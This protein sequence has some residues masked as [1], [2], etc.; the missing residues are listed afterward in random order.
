MAWAHA[1]YTCAKCGGHIHVSVESTG[2]MTGPFGYEVIDG[3]KMKGKLYCK[4][5]Y[6]EEHDKA[7]KEIRAKYPKE[8]TEDQ[9]LNMV[10]EIFDLIEI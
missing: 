10:H 2:R 6:N 8:M 4:K 9:K 3:H 7:L 1:G 5:C